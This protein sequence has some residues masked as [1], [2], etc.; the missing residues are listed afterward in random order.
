ML[1][2]SPPEYK[3]EPE[4]HVHILTKAYEGTQKENNQKFRHIGVNTSQYRQS[5]FPKKLLVP[6]IS[7]HML[8]P[9]L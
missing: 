4:P 2:V 5:F 8:I 9:Q 6:G 7:S 3:P 1:Q